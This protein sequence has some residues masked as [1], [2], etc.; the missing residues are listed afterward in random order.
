[1]MMK[2]TEGATENF[3]KEELCPVPATMK[4]SHANNAVDRVK[5]TKRQRTQINRI[6]NERNFIRILTRKSEK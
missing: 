3:L 6:G 1:M 4:L 5:N 2:K